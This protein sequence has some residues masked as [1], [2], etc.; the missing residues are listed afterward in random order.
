MRNSF[1][2]CSTFVVKGIRWRRGPVA[3]LG[4][5]PVA[6]H[7]DT[8]YRGEFAG[9]RT[10]LYA[11]HS[12]RLI[13]LGCLI[14]TFI[15]AGLF[16]SPEP[17]AAQDGYGNVFGYDDH[18]A[19][20]LQQ[21]YTLRAA[22][23]RR[24]TSSNDQAVRRRRVPYSDNHVADSTAGKRDKNSKKE[25]AKK[26]APQ[27]AIYAIVSLADQ[28]VTVYDSTGRIAQSR[29]STGMPGHPTPIG[30]FSIIGKERWHRSNI[31]SGAPMPFM[32]RITWSGVAMH[33]GVVPGY[34]ASHGCI[35]LPDGFAQQFWGMTQIGSRVMVARRDTTPVEISSTFLPV[36]KLRPAPEVLP[37]SQQSSLPSSTPVKLASISEASPMSAAAAQETQPS[38]ATAAKLLNPIEYAKALKERALASKAAADQA[39][40]DALRAAQAAGAEAH[41]AM[42]DVNKAETDLRAAE[43]KLAALEP[44]PRPLAAAAAHAG[45]PGSRCCSG[46][47][48]SDSAGAAAQ[49]EIDRARAALV[50]A[51][52]REATK[53]QVAFAAVQTWKDAVAAAGACGGHDQRGR[54]PPEARVG[55]VQQEGRPRL[56]SPGLE[57]GLRSAHNLQRPGS[58]D[59][60][61]SLHRGQWRR[62]RQ[63]EVVGHLRTVWRQPSDDPQRKRSKNDK[64][65]DTGA[66]TCS[67]GRHGLC[68]ARPS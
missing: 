66:C 20:Q 27:G 3:S 1:C 40:K 22:R 43:A 51:Q 60:N 4:R 8:K 41:Q 15:A 61:P 65:A 24:A 31:Y 25:E 11:S 46:S 33:L 6:V 18:R 55:L 53:R 32:Q 34:P 26:S 35:R 14:A 64:S 7:L 13:A 47:S 5:A 36:P 37:G 48:F 59:R 29:I 42:D 10:D 16:G 38:P 28:H 9:V 49:V 67:S 44:R 19:E 63:G 68:G 2:G 21:R 17:A 12:A 45:R 30:L 57:R 50:E 54:A 58:S 39:A 52:S 56:H 62:G 23:S